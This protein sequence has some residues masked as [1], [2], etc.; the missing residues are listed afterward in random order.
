VEVG[1]KGI[2]PDRLRAYLAI[3]EELGSPVLRTLNDA[4]GRRPTPDEAV[5]LLRQVTPDFERAGVH[6]A[7]ENHDRLPAATLVEI[8]SRVGSRRLGI[9]LDTAN[10]LG[11][12]EGTATVVE[13]LGPHAV[14]LHVKDCRVARLPHEKG[15]VVEGCPA[16]R[17][18]LDVP[19]LLARVRSFGRA[20]SAILEL[21]PPPEADV[22][23]SVSKERAWAEES[24]RYL[25]HYLPD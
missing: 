1:T 9:C 7:I 25:R 14:N 23:A 18:Q 17:G 5:A 19:A 2:A 20:P 4:D 15:F 22:E 3:A 6:L 21:W 16:G 13:T 8:L 24:V 10:S 12:L 11:C